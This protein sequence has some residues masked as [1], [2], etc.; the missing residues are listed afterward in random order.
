MFETRSMEPSSTTTPWKSYEVKTG[1]VLIFPGWLEHMVEPSR[2]HERRVV[3]TINWQID[4]HKL[5]KPV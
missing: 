2:S 4:W 1:D 3:M 5:P